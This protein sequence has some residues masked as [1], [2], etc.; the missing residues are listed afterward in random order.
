MSS[1]GFSE[2]ENHPDKIDNKVDHIEKKVE[3]HICLFFSICVW[4]FGRWNQSRKEE[5]WS[6]D[7]IEKWIRE[8]NKETQK[9]A[10]SCPSSSLVYASH[11]FRNYPCM[12][13]ND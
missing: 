4:V 3:I 8:D 13:M 11:M 1:S 10:Y 2:E 12:K 5:I 6:Y 9:Q 7:S